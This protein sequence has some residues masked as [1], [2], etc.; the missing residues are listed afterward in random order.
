[1]NLTYTPTAAETYDKYI[2]TGNSNAVNVYSYDSSQLIHHNEFGNSNNITSLL[3]VSSEKKLYAGTQNNGVI[4]FD[5][6]DPENPQPTELSYN[7][8]APVKDMTFS[9][10][11]L[12]IAHLEKVT[13]LN[14]ELMTK[15]HEID[16]ENTVNTIDADENFL[17]AGINKGIKIYTD[18]DKTSYKV[19]TTHSTKGNVLDMLL[20]DSHL[21]SAD[22]RSGFSISEYDKEAGSDPDP[23]DP[24]SG[25]SSSC[26]IKTLF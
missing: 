12:Y 24:S 13:V 9:S 7:I 14:S 11:F 2:Y 8:P 16:I 18:A 25:E 4:V 10:N 26:F 19:L 5:I 17:F 22:S 20:K 23:L 3:A 21:F 15:K 1:M 6:S